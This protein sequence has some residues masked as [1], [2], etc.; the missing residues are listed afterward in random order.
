[1]RVIAEYVM[2][3]RREALSISVLGAALPL[4]YWL[5]TAVI[6]LVVLR[7]GSYEGSIILLWASLPALIWLVVARDPTPIITMVGTVALAFILRETVS[8]IYTLAVSV[9]LGVAAGWMLEVALP[10]I[11][12]TLVSVTV[13][14][15]QESSPQPIL[16]IDQLALWSQRWLVGMLGAWQAGFML[17]CLMLAR[18][19]QS[20]LYNPGGLRQEL[21]QLRLPPGMAAALIALMVVC[22]NIVDPYL[23][24]WIPV[25]TVPL[26][27]A[28]ISLVHWGVARSNS[29]KNWLLVFYL[30]FLFFQQFVYPL[31]LLVALTDS[32][33]DVR[34]RASGTAV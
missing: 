17:L 34:R 20:V 16:E 3:G 15:M 6:S 29:S 18:W 25:L 22:V 33:I 5:S 7:K 8:W 24:G 21:H 2:R 12:A 30:F 11:V 27:V 31:L 19:W 13:E 9:L 32:W 14:Y 26:V 4:L 1:M 28:G 23:A 10:E